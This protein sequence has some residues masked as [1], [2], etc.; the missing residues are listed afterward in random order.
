MFLY[1]NDLL[2]ILHSVPTAIK[3]KCKS[4]QNKFQKIFAPSLACDGPLLSKTFPQL[5]K[6]VVWA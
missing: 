5:K 1:K 6:R 3:N 2:P 4:G